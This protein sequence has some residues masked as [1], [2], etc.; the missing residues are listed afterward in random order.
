M[1]II[2]LMLLITWTVLLGGFTICVQEATTAYA[3]AMLPS[4][5]R[6][7]QNILT[8][9]SQIIRNS[10]L[11]ISASF[12]L[13]YSIF[14]FNWY[15]AILVSFFGVS[16]QTLAWKVIKSHKGYE[17]F[18]QIILDDLNKRK[19]K[20][21]KNDDAQRLFAVNEVISGLIHFDQ[22]P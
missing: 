17:Y 1:T 2:I 10:L 21:E 19:A 14:V 9:K 13:V 8:P 18:R 16:L 12:V 5:P 15:I 7:M 4:N 22:L 20:Y 6:H 11:F 3:K